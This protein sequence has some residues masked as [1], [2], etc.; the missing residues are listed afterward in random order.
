LSLVERVV[1]CICPLKRLVSRFS[2]AGVSE[3]GR[4]FGGKSIEP[5]TGSA[6]MA[7]SHIYGRW[8]LM[9][10]VTKHNQRI[11]I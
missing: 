11:N 2:S 10:A 4:A 1:P 8:I 6:L 5:L 7:D 3:H 9:T